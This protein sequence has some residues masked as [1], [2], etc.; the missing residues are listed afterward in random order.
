MHLH[1]RRQQIVHHN[2][3]NVFAVALE[4][5]QAEELGQQRARILAQIQIV[6]GQQFLQEFAL[7]V[8]HRFDD[9]LI[10]AGQIEN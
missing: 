10:V 2:Q 6:A 3:S 7:L 8:L 4:A 1:V 9:E 5:I